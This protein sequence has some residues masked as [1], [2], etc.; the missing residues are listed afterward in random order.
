MRRRIHSRL[1]YSL[2]TL[3]VV[4]ALV[5]ALATACGG[6]TGSKSNQPAGNGTTSS[7]PGTTNAGTSTSKSGWG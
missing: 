5:A 6:S 4:L 1:I 2:A 7:S 3:S